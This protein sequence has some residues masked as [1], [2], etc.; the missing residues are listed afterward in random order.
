[1]TT[2]RLKTDKFT[3]EV[4]PDPDTP[5]AFAYYGSESI[6]VND[7]I[8][9]TP[10]SEEK[11]AADLIACLHN[12]LSLI[13]PYDYLRPLM[14][15]KNFKVSNYEPV[16]VDNSDQDIEI[17][18]NL[19][20]ERGRVIMWKSEAPITVDLETENAFRALIDLEPISRS[21]GD[22]MELF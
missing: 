19:K 18:D 1:M 9:R 3:I 14:H 4:Y 12:A 13:F 6:T 11:A 20:W 2:Y 5:Q 10:Y 21:S 17:L 7:I 16:P 22:Q 15:L 8:L